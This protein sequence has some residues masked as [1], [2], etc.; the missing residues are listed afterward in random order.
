MFDNRTVI[1]IVTW[2]FS[3]PVLVLLVMTLGEQCFPNHYCI[4]N[5]SNN[6]MSRLNK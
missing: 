1:E 3:R 5:Y 6:G 2:I 4:I